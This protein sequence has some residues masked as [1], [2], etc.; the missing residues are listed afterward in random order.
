MC[1]RPPHKPHSLAASTSVSTAA[2][3]ASAA[4]AITSSTSTSTS[5]VSPTIPTIRCK[6]A[7]NVSALGASICAPI[8]A[9]LAARLAHGLW[10]GGGLFAGTAAH[11]YSQQLTTYVSHTSPLPQSSPICLTLALTN[12]VSLPK[13]ASGNLAQASSVLDATV[14]QQKRNTHSQ[15]EV[16]LDR[17]AKRERPRK[18]HLQTAVASAQARPCDPF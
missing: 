15:S 8:L 1:A 17:S 4:S 13:A 11:F 6:S 12:A 10:V 16:T 7:A 3:A 14:P 2:S 5:T 18:T 9:L